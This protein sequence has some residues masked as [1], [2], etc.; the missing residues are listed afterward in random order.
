MSKTS[1]LLNFFAQKDNFKTLHQGQL[2]GKL[3]QQLQMAAELSKGQS[4]RARWVCG[5]E[6]THT[7]HHYAPARTKLKAKTIGILS[8]NQER[9]RPKLL[10]SLGLVRWKTPQSECQTPRQKMIG[11]RSDGLERDG[12]TSTISNCLEIQNRAL[13]YELPMCKTARQEH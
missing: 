9:K 10:W 3:L 7:I 13:S 5:G 2:P 8:N 12:D 4:T 11:P 1:V 6:N